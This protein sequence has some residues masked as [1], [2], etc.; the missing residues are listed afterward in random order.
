MNDTSIWDWEPDNWS[1][2][3]GRGNERCA[4]C[5]SPNMVYQSRQTIAQTWEQPGEYEGFWFCKDC[6]LES[7]WLAECTCRPETQHGL[8][9]EACGYCKS[10]FGDEIP[11]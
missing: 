5:F 4:G 9:G 8:S 6:D 1:Y 3:E 10:L 7:E 11:Y 2:M